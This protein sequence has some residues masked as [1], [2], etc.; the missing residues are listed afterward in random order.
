MGFFVIVAGI[1]SFDTLWILVLKNVFVDV[2][3]EGYLNLQKR[4]PNVR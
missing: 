4:A 2:I 1:N 3:Y